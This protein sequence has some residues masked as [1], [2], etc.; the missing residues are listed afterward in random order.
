MFHH[1]FP[2]DAN[3]PQG[4]YREMVCD[5]GISDYGVHDGEST[6]QSWI[7]RNV[8]TRDHGGIVT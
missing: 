1:R 5:A 6:V 2:P 7:P 4:R 8:H 3:V